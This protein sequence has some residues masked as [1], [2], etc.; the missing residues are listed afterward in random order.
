[1]P[2]EKLREEWNQTEYANSIKEI[3]LSIDLFRGKPHGYHKSSELILDWWINK[4]LEREKEL[5]VNIGM[6]RQWLNEDRI[7]DP[8]KMVTNEQVQKW[9]QLLD[10]DEK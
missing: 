8:N 5:S 10:I 2:I 6:L 3:D 9:L 7:D 1:M 4:I